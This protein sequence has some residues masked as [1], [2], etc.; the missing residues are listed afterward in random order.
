VPVA[1]AARD[2]QVANVRAFAGVTHVWWTTERA[3]D[4]SALARRIA[5]LAADP[6]ALRDAGERMRLAATPGAATAFF[7]ACEAL[8]TR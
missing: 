7:E 2:H 1:T 6:V 8:V 5:D 4:G 3:W